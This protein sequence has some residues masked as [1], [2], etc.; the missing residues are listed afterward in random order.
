[1]L[2]SI[3]ATIA[4]VALRPAVQS[5]RELSAKSAVYSYLVEIET[6]PPHLDYGNICCVPKRR[7]C[8]RA[9][10]EIVYRVCRGAQL[11]A[12]KEEEG[13]CAK[14]HVGITARLV[15]NFIIGATEVSNSAGLQESRQYASVMFSAKAVKACKG[16]NALTLTEPGGCHSVV[17]AVTSG[18]ASDND[19]TSALALPPYHPSEQHPF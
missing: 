17:T 14:G 11:K 10:R 2:R 3:G 8:A 16:R 15:R 5:D 7:I 6:V 18:F 19:A 1:M 12:T 9:R 4:S 13:Y